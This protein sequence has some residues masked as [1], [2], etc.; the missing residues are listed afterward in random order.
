M[1]EVDW[2]LWAGGLNL[3]AWVGRNNRSQPP[4]APPDLLDNGEITNGVMTSAFT[5]APTL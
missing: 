4:A 1:P 3:S 5:P 2:H